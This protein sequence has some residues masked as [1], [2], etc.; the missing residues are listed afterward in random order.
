MTSSVENTLANE[1][2]KVI[3]QGVRLDDESGLPA[4][5]RL[6]FEHLH[7]RSYRFPI[8]VQ[9]LIELIDEVESLGFHRAI[10]VGYVLML[11]A[12]KVDELLPAKV[13]ACKSF[14]E[15][16]ELICDAATCLL[17]EFDDQD[18]KSALALI[19]HLLSLISEPSEESLLMTG[20]V[21]EALNDNEL[22][23]Q[24]LAERAHN[25]FEDLYD[26]GFLNPQSELEHDFLR[27]NG[28]NFIFSYML[29]S[30]SDKLILMA[31]KLIF[32]FGHYGDDDYILTKLANLAVRGNYHAWQ[33]IQEVWQQDFDADKLISQLISSG[34]NQSLNAG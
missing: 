24:Y 27:V 10:A 15:L 33:V 1:I 11:L 20:K 3:V 16:C 2:R 13:V 30:N 29:A 23:K 31:V 34:L 5:F 32:N 21:K 26:K 9:K 22:A 4:A 17:F 28:K 8:G 19:D 7:Y 12:K 6:I 25:F 18:E 14:T